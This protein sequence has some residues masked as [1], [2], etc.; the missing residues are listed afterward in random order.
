MGCVREGE[1]EREKRRDNNELGVGCGGGMGCDCWDVVM[2]T[3]LCLVGL[4]RLAAREW[5]PV[6]MFYAWIG[7]LYLY[8]F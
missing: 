7:F 1:K 8:H 3:V 4:H 5:L 2:K 6:W